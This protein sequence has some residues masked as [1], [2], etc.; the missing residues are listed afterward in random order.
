MIAIYKITNRL[1]WKI[2]VGQTHQ[3]IEKRFLQHSK[4]PSPLG[5]A[6]RDCG[7]E[8]FTIEVIEECETQKQANERER[9]WIRVLKSKMPNGYNRSNGGEVSIREPQRVAVMATQKRQVLIRVQPD[10]YE[11]L[12]AI[13]DKN[14]RSVSNQMEWLMLQFI[15]EYEAQ[16][17]SIPLLNKNMG[18]VQNNSSGTN[19]VAIGGNKYNSGTP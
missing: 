19:L 5:D 9:F 1:N 12:K 4:A 3:P 13:S 2:Y 7:I 10:T 17:G 18:V 11:K 14:H 16:N 8:N 6:M 15:S